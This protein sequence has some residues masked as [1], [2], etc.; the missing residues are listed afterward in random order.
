[1]NAPKLRETDFIAAIKARPDIRIFLT[2]GQDDS[3]ISAIA[4]AQARQLPDDAEA[5]DLDSGRLRQDPAILLDEA[6]SSSLFGGA[7]YIRVIFNREEGVDAVANLLDAAQAGN[8]VIATAGNLPKTSKL[9]KLLQNNPFALSFIC[10]PP[11]DADAADRVGALARAAGLKMDHALAAQIAR[12]TGNDRQLAAAEIEKLALYYDATPDR[13]AQVERQALSALAAETAEDDISGLVN[14][15]LGGDIKTLGKELVTQRAI[16]LD[17][18][19]IIRAL[20]RRLVMLAGLRGK[21]DHGAQ[22]GA[23]V[24]AARGIFWKEQDAYVQQ[25]HRWTSRRLSSL[26]NHL[27]GLEA[28][29]MANNAESGSIMLEQELTRIARAAARSR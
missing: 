21:M 16:G 19:R 23:L 9:L 22:A 29:L 25:L 4:K 2:Y 27:L 13:P 20:Q 11:N 10:Y 14:L 17:G 18:I 3:A 1:M 8:P 12:Y 28:R 7:R 5:V 26:N 15:V 24:R 6:A